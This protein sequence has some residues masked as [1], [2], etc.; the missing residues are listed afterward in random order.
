MRA[1]SVRHFFAEAFQVLL[2]PT[3]IAKLLLFQS[4]LLV[5][6]VKCMRGGKKGTKTKSKTD[7]PGKNARGQQNIPQEHQISDPK[8]R[9][10]P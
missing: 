4:R 7:D 5:L 2:R 6:G 1:A 3:L 10:G 8:S 9:A